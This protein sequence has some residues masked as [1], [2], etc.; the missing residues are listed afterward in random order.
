MSAEQVVEKSFVLND[1]QL[2][3]SLSGIND[4]H[5]KLIEEGLDVDL[6]PFGGTIKLTGAE[7][8]VALAYQ[9]LS[10]LTGLLRKKITIS[11]ADVVSAMKMAQ[12]GTLEYFKDLYTEEL[13]KDRTTTPIFYQFFSIKIFEVF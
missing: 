11:S 1:S 9:V 5:L 7:E 3:I 12:R 8:N 10:E 2:Q 13:I 4:S 6:S